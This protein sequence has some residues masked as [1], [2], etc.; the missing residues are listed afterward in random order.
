MLEAAKQLGFEQTLLEFKD[1]IGNRD[2]L[3]ETT[4]KERE[5]LFSDIENLADTILIRSSHGRSYRPMIRIEM[6]IDGVRIPAKVSVIHRHD[7]KYPVIVG[8]RNLRKFL[9]DVNK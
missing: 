9:V 7:M 5:H 3:Q 8:K 6:E 1:R 4:K 2:I